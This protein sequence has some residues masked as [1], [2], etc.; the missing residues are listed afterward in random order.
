M[1]MVVFTQTHLGSPFPLYIHTRG[2]DSGLNE[3]QTCVCCVLCVSVRVHVCVCCLGGL[4]TPCLRVEA[5]FI[6]LQ[7]RCNREGEP[8]QAHGWLFVYLPFFFISSPLPTSHKSGWKSSAA[9]AKGFQQNKAN[10]A[11]RGSP[12]NISLHQIR[13]TRDC[14]TKDIR[15]SFFF[16]VFFKCN[17][18]INC[19]HALTLFF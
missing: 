18:R 2:S 10:L 7:M 16:V 17:I 13:S 4:L 6:R 19:H 1:S 8:E 14:N 3:Q 5:W 11:T 15:N 9:R 12:L